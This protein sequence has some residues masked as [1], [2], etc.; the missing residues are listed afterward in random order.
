MGLMDE[1]PVGPAVPVVRPPVTKPE[2]AMAKS[3]PAPV[4]GPA[5]KPR[6]VKDALRDLVRM[7]PKKR[8]A[9]A[10]AGTVV[11]A[12]VAINALLSGKNLEPAT[13]APALAVAPP[14]PPWR[15]LHQPR[16]L[17]TSQTNRQPHPRSF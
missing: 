8:V 17:R 7:N 4:G 10:V 5:P 13:E 9:L 11:V 2:P 1:I 14:A 12:A 6:W 3:E 16:P 15:L